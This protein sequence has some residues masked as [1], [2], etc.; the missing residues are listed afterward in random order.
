ME[1][2]FCPSTLLRLPMR[3]GCVLRSTPSAS[4]AAR[5]ARMA[6]STSHAQLTSLSHHSHD[7]TLMARTTLARSSP[8]SPLLARPH[9][10]GPRH[11]RSQ[12]TGNRE[13]HDDWEVD[14]GGHNEEG[15]CDDPPRLWKRDV[16][17]D[18]YGHD[19]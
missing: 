18:E 16:S 1:L 8:H 15:A 9:S 5:G 12:L 10:D 7:P 14:M 4:F 11:P 17:I 13:F 3:H 6:H 19:L 2:A